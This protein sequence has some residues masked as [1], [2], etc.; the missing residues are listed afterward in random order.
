MKILYDY[1]C[2]TQQIGGV[3]RYHVELIKNL[4][5]GVDTILQPLLSKNVYLKEIGHP[6]FDL[7]PFLHSKKKGII[8]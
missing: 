6:C 7:L 2:Y 3:S 4:S 5:K 8:I 1:V